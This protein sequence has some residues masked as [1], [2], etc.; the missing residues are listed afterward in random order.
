MFFGF[1]IPR[2]VPEV[3][4]SF[5]LLKSNNGS[6]NRSA[7]PAPMYGCICMYMYEYYI[8]MYV[9]ILYQRVNCM[10]RMNVMCSGVNLIYQREDLHCS[11][12][13]FGYG[14]NY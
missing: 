12:I 8:R 6:E 7:D 10:L 2:T 13:C 11:N 1:D 9:D 14:K 5:L 4:E 3:L